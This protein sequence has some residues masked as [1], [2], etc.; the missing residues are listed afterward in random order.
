[1]L[2]LHLRLLNTLQLDS[3]GHGNIVEIPAEATLVS[4]VRNPIHPRKDVKVKAAHHVLRIVIVRNRWFP[5]E[6][7]FLPGLST[8]STY[9]VRD[10]EIL[11]I[12]S[13]EYLTT[14]L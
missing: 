8:R 1:M 6:C 14:Y 11:L 7:H 3:C 4:S 2:C 10:K 12:S 13:R 9:S 5:A